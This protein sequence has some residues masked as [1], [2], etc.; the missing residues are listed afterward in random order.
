MARV[1]YP[2]RR[3]PRTPKRTSKGVASSRLLAPPR[4]L[5]APS[6]GPRRALVGPWSR[7][8]STTAARQELCKALL[9]E[10]RIGAQVRLELLLLLEED[11]L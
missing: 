3:V 4:A 9:L 5:L 2:V 10:R 7:R 1:I 6:S 8:R 11:R